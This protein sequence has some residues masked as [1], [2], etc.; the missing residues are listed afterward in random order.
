MS[1]G[2]ARARE[3]L[4]FL[5]AT[6]AVPANARFGALS[7][8]PR[9]ITG[10]TALYGFVLDAHPEDNRGAF[11]LRLEAD[12]GVASTL[13]VDAKAHALN[14]A[15]GQ[16]LLVTGLDPAKVYDVELTE[17]SPKAVS[18]AGEQSELSKVA[19]AGEQGWQV[20]E[21]GRRAQL[22][23]TST[24]A[25]T[26]PDDAAYDNGGSLRVRVVEAPRR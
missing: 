17:G 11:Q 7:S 22:T 6:D 9:T 21:V 18:R 1:S 13:E 24:L 26:F 23:G 14:P 25:F 20:L 19:V 12:A 5:D 2:P 10:A 15:L 3:V 16:R 8:Q 4:Y